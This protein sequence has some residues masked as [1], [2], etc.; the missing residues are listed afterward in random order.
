MA[1]EIL[2]LL[3]K[4]PELKVIGRTS[5]YSFKGKTNDLRSI[6]S[7]LGAAYVVEGSVRRSVDHIRITAQ[8]IDTRDGAHHWS[9][10]YD[11]DVSD[12]LKTH[13]K[14][15]RPTHFAG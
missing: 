6:G 14:L 10:T 3:V 11:R 8:L 15:P 5:S 13:L 2:N 1:E 4:I 9:D 7:A 12:V